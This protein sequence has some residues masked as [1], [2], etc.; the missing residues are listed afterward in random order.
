MAAST[1][2]VRRRRRP[3]RGS[4]AR[5]VNA[6]LYRAS[7]L[8]VALP[9][10]LLAF[11]INKPPAL[12]KPVLPGSFDTG[13]AVALATDLS[14][15]YPDRAP[16]TAGA[17]GAASWFRDQLPTQVYGLRTTTSTWKQA[18]PGL[19]KGPLTN[20]VTVAPGQSSGQVIVVMAHRDDLGTGPGANDNASGT[21]ALIELA[22][23]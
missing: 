10:L 2:T 9:V 5:P 19:G 17:I 6:S 7:F 14:N 1:P 13:A 4:L 11:T 12:A 15:S 21:A 23:S 18:V 16:G 8:I 20:I 3:R 22:R